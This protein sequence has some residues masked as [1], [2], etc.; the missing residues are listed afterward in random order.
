MVVLEFFGRYACFANHAPHLQ[1]NC[2]LT[3]ILFKGVPRLYLIAKVD[4][5]PLNELRYEYVHFM[6]YVKKDLRMRDPKLAG[7]RCC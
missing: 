7:C 2:V 5:A 4:I 1:A 3:K 6:P